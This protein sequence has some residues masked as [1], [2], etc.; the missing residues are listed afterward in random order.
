MESFCVCVRG[1]VVSDLFFSLV[2]TYTRCSPSLSV[3]DDRPKWRHWYHSI[4]MHHYLLACSLSF[5]MFHTHSKFHSIGTVAKSLGKMYIYANS[6]LMHTKITSTHNRGRINNC[7]LTKW[8][9]LRSNAFKCETILHGKSMD[10]SFGRLWCWHLLS[11][12]YFIISSWFRFSLISN[13][14]SYCLHNSIFPFL[15]PPFVMC[16]NPKNSEV[17][18]L[19]SKWHKKQKKWW[20]F[21]NIALSFVLIKN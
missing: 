4:N 6:E 12:G 9:W 7:N 2:N 14:C 1:S 10:I 21:L 8:L 17:I 13:P 16:K 15:I 20:T 18:L 5:S 11:L 3:S 19:N